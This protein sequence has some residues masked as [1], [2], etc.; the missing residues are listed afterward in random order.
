MIMVK[1]EFSFSI[2]PELNLKL[3]TFECTLKMIFKAN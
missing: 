1:I 3:Y 2:M